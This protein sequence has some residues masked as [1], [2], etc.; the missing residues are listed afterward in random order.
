ML[1]SLKILF[2]LLCTL[3]LWSSAFVGIRAALHAFSPEGLACF[4][5]LIASL[6]MLILYFFIPNR[7]PV[8]FRHQLLMLLT[9]MIA[10]AFY[11]I[12]L[13]YGEITVSSAEASFIVSQSPL[14]SALF[15]RVFLKESISKMQYLGF[16]ISFAGI[17][18]IA[19]GQQAHFN[20][21]QGMVWLV[22]TTICAAAYNLLQKPLLSIYSPLQVTA[23][24][25][26][27]GELFLLLFF[28]PLMLHD[29]SQATGSS[30]ILVV[31][32]G[33]GPAILAYWGWAY[34]LS[35]MPAS[36]AVGLLYALPICTLIV[37]WICLSEIPTML[38]I[39]GGLFALIGVW[40][41][42]AYRSVP[43]QK[44]K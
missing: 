28:S 34:I 14:L 12:T 43:T 9:G 11:N 38:S 23:W 15:A 16:T 1:A 33:I 39:M 22:L 19:L 42:N 29:L 13:N 25:M 30:V 31:Y 4:R 37:A 32:L 6:G 44:Q 8:L 21:H 26:W 10:I 24:V 20:W 27:G 35:H 41:I 17:L 2:I 36:R 40:F 3:V 18:L 7:K 5:Y